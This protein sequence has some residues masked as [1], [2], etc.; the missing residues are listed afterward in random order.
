MGKKRKKVN[1]CLK[2]KAGERAA[3]AFLRHLGFPDA[4]R[5]EQHSGKGGHGDV[6]CPNLL[7]N[8]HFEVKFGMP[9]EKFDDGSKALRH[10]CLQARRDADGRAWCVLWKP[11]RCQSWR[12]TT[13]LWIA[14]SGHLEI[15]TTGDEDTMTAW[16]RDTQA[17]SDNALEVNP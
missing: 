5:S 10:A 17:A 13:P 12:L 16:L 14:G 8:I 1:S 3:A 4:I 11:Y 15:W 9:R 7:P 6:M 2:G